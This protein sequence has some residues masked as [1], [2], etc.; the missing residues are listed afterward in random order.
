MRNCI[1]IKFNKISNIFEID[2]LL[3]SL[4][5]SR[6]FAWKDVSANLLL[7]IRNEYGAKE[8]IIS[9]FYI[10]LLF[11]IIIILLLLKFDTFFILLN[12]CDRFFYFRVKEARN[13]WYIPQKISSNPFAYATL[14]FT[15]DK[16]LDFDNSFI[17][18]FI[19]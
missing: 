15:F 10:W 5:V 8:D 6:G 14:L 2:V 19:Q 9:Y 4:T 1:R 7:L 12:I 16:D 17:I 13:G 11:S 18:L 3:G